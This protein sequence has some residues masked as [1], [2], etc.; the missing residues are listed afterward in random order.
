MT[1]FIDYKYNS[2]YVATSGGWSAI[3]PKIQQQHPPPGAMLQYPAKADMADTGATPTDLWWSAVTTGFGTVV[4]MLSYKLDGKKYLTLFEIARLASWGS[5]RAELILNFLTASKMSSKFTHL[6]VEDFYPIIDQSEKV[7]V[8]YLLGCAMAGISGPAA[9]SSRGRASV[10]RLFH[11]SLLRDHIDPCLSIT[12]NSI[13]DKRPDFL[14]FD[15]NSG[16]HVFESKASLD[17]TNY[18][19]ISEGLLQLAS[20]SNISLGCGLTLAPSSLNVCFAFA[21]PTAVNQW[22][23]AAPPVS[24]SPGVRNVVVEYDLPTLPAR[25]PKRIPSHAHHLLA[26]KYA[27]GIWLLLKNSEEI[28]SKWDDAGWRI[29][30]LSG[31][32]YVDRIALPRQLI[33]TWSN[34][35]D[36]VINAWNQSVLGDKPLPSPL[37]WNGFT[38]A[39]MNAGEELLTADERYRD[40]RP[41]AERSG[42]EPIFPGFKPTQSDRWLLLSMR[43]QDLNQG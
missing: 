12:I 29:Y 20:V 2:I 43:A 8:S 26:G 37:G 21:S 19:R 36:S 42:D 17:G 14:G 38:Q 30:R 5:I 33:D 11:A 10:G 27:F 34:I 25:R 3:S 40:D 13:S 23:I 7:T 22:P 31:S 28:H 6:R 32:S 9:L 15:K 24:I 18:G 4:E 35:F 41:A 1:A 39:F 16:I